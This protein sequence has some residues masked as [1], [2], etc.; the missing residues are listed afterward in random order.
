MGLVGDEALPREQ[1]HSASLYLSV[2]RTAFLE[3]V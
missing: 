2:L 1:G 3:E